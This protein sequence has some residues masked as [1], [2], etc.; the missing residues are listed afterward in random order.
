MEKTKLLEKLT[1]NNQETPQTDHL[2]EKALSCRNRNQVR[3]KSR[4]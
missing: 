1:D 4:D 3:P 2:Q